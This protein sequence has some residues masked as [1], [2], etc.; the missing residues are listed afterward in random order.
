MAYFA[1]PHVAVAQPFQFG[2]SRSTSVQLS[3]ARVNTISGSIATRLEQARAL[4]K[5]RNW[6]DAIDILRE[7]AAERSDGIVE[8]GD[9]RYVSL[10]TACHMELANLPAEGLSAY[11]RRVDVLADRL[12]REG[13]VRRNV[14]LLRR[15]ADEFFCSSWGDDALLV[16]GELALERGDYAAARR[17]WE[18]MS[19]LLRGPAG[20]PLWLALRD[21]DLAAHWPQIERRWH[22][23]PN[24][25]MWLAYPDTPVDLADVRAR[26]IL[27]SIRAGDLKRARI[28]L[29]AFRRFHP[30]SAGRLGGQDGPYAAALERL[31]A[32]ASAWPSQPPQ[33]DWPTFAGSPS[34][35]SA[36]GM[37][38]PVTGPIWRQPIELTRAA[39]ADRNF[40]MAATRQGLMLD[41][42]QL[43][44]RE[45]ARPLS[46]FPVVV[47]GFVLYADATQIYA[48]DLMTGGP[49][50]TKNGVLHR[51]DSLEQPHETIDGPLAL[52]WRDELVAAHGVPRY[53]LSVIDGTVFGRVGRLA[54]AQSDSGQ[55]QAA[56]RI[57]GLDL[58]RD[59][60]LAFRVR[61]EES[62]WAFDGVPVGD[63]RRLFVAMH[64]SDV[65]PHA[66]VACFDVATSGQLWRT[67]IGAA[68]TP[69]AGYGDEITHNLLTLVGDR[70]YFNTNLGLVAALDANSGELC[71]LRRYDRHSG[72]PIIR[73][74]PQPPHLARDP[75]PALFHEGLLIVAPSDTPKIFALDADTG[76]TVWST[77]FLP[78][79]IHLLGVARN[80]LIVSGNRLAALDVRSGELRFAW[81]ES[82]HAG[83]RGMGRG[84]VAGD[85]VFW[86][87][88]NEI[89]VIHGITGAQSRTPIPL[90]AIS[91]CG[92]NLAAA[93][94]RL[95]VAGPDKLMAFG[96][97]LPVPPTQSKPK[98]EPVAKAE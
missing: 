10:R 34:R 21:V 78:D 3:P 81:P 42:S 32:N 22:D 15:V 77:D 71:W 90:G 88:R 46:C 47:N 40:P 50:I 20:Q 67:P 94:G 36:T 89:Y 98:T 73:G 63:G 27:T 92:A 97:K 19:P 39:A 82:E 66:Y 56:D 79:V 74:R 84:V 51:E 55:S 86:P 70:I 26:L 69:A 35:S 65:T 31:I 2:A 54:T 59:G 6:D 4:S 64:Q 23:R 53:T 72:Q 95:L 12:Y 14:R 68:D 25:P 41:S 76:Q 62:K 45:A 58:E 28:E 30:D 1:A 91:D 33:A 5:D 93:T 61:P 87:T 37:L 17:T 83:I 43:D 18:Q 80:N 16:L 44:V 85:E 52:G 24:P 8:L 60:A 11:R 29:A 38:G 7:L 13:R 49:A 48:S 96:A 9:G 75:A 57:V